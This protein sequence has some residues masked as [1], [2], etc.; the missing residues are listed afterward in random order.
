MFNVIYT[1]SLDNADDIISKSFDYEDEK[2][3]IALFNEK[4]QKLMNEILGNE[5]LKSKISIHRHKALIKMENRHYVIAIVKDSGIFNS[6][7]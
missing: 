1:E 7:K 3:A 2:D 6:E 4:V 5:Y